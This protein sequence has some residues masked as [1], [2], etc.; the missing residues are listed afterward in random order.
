M[1][2]LMQRFESGNDLDGLWS[3]DD[4]LGRLVRWSLSTSIGDAEPSPEAWHTILERVREQPTSG[5]AQP[6]SRCFSAPLAALVQAAVVG[7][8]LMTLGLG[9]R[10]DV[11]VARSSLAA[12]VAPSSESPP[13]CEPLRAAIPDRYSLTGLDEEERPFRAGGNI[14]EATLPS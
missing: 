2:S 10:R 13:A 3:D 9:V 7:C 5:R 14:R 8:V 1:S 12:A 11:I 4:E 6:D